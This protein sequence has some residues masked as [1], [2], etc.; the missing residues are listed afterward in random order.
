MTDI[1]LQTGVGLILVSVLLFTLGF[2]FNKRQNGETSMKIMGYQSLGPKKGIAMVK[3][4]QETLIVGV[5]AT[6]V[7]LLK[8][9]D[10]VREDAQAPRQPDQPKEA[11]GEDT[12][13]RIQKLRALKDALKDSLYAVK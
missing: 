4:G 10:P 12:P 5:T 3:V 6:D 2:Y 11:I 1:Y 8:T 7:K 13:G 9:M